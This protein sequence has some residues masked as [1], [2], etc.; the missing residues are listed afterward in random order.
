MSSSL[1][2]CYQMTLATYSPGIL[3]FSEEDRQIL[4]SA[5]ETH[6]AES[7]F[8]NNPKHIQLLDLT[9]T[10]IYIKLTSAKA[11]STPGRGLGRFTALLLE[12]SRFA[13]RVVSGHVFR[14]IAI[15]R[16][17]EEKVKNP[18]AISDMELIKAL[19]DYYDE[20]KD[21]SSAAKK[22]RAAIEEMKRLA[23]EVNIIP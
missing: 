9:D 17:A 15:Q 5:I 11:L 13:Q 22:K 12:H 14:V 7:I 1:P 3:P 8:M 21:G 18:A 10:C 23:V 4:E 2:Y 19:L 20:K 16:P 6:N